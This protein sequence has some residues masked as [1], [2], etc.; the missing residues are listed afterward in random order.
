MV[1]TALVLVTGMV[2]IFAW[3]P[4]VHHN[5]SWATGGDLWGIYRGAHYVAWGSLG[6]IYTSGTGIVSFPGMAILLAPVAWTTGHFHMSESYGPFFIP[7]PT[8]ALVLM[9]VELLLG[10]TV[11]FASDAL[12]ERLGVGRT[13]RIWLCLSVGVLAWLVVEV[14]GHAEDALAVTFAMYAMIAML[15]RKWALMGWLFGLG[16]LM[17]PLVALLLPLFIGASPRGSAVPVG[18]AVLGALGGPGRRGL[19]R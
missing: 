7:R 14:W 2:F 10:S 17:Q 3:N 6:G 4:L 9:P 19:R 12:A 8:A 11:I 13:R 16:I 1:T 5:G 15:N 18:R